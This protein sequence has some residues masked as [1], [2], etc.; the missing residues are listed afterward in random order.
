MSLDP[1]WLFLSLVAGGGGFV[2]FVYGKKQQRWPQLAAG[3]IFMA[4]PYFATSLVSLVAIGVVIGC[5]LWYAIRL[6]W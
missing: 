1:A 6:G 4:Y 2:L 3:L 5:V